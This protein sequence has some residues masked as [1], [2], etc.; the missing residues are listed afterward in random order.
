MLSRWPR[1]GNCMTQTEPPKQNKQ[2]QKFSKM[3]PN[4]ILLNSQNQC[5]ARLSSELL[6]PAADQRHTAKHQAMKDSSEEGD[7]GPQ[8][9]GV[10]RTLEEPCPQNQITEFIG[11]HRDRGGNKRCCK[12]HHQDLCT[13]AMVFQIRD[14]VGLLTVGV[15]LALNIYLAHG[16]YFLLQSCIFQLWYEVICPVFLHLV[17]LSSIDIPGKPVLF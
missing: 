16:N 12:G 7:E 3:I 17:M 9:P 5:L 14:F 2:K 8:G 6:P 1:S 11:A 10:S 13:H 15:G 4:G